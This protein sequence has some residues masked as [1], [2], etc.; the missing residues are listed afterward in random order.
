MATLSQ[1]LLVRSYQII[2]DLQQASH[3]FP[4]EGLGTSDRAFCQT[5]CPARRECIAIGLD[6]LRGGSG[7]GGVKGTS[8]SRYGPELAVKGLC[9]PLVG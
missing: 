6:V 1:I 7:P 9:Y 4:V 8:G 5:A 2:F 3:W